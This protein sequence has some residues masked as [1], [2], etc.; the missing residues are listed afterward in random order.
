MSKH[1]SEDYKITAVKY[2]L[3]NDI[4]YT[5]TCNI[6]NKEFYVC[7]VDIIINKIQKCLKIEKN[8]DSCNKL[9]NGNMIGG[10]NV[11][12]IIDNL[13][14]YYKKKYEYYNQLLI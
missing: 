12:Y 1:K 13:L 14:K 10:G 2:Y 9:G 5:K 4:N 8:C 11:N 3:E 7:N 6:F